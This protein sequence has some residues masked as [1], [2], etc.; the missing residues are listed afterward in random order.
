MSDEINRGGSAFPINGYDYG[1]TLRDYIAI[2]V[3]QGIYAF[4]P[5]GRTFEYGC[6][7]ETY[8]SR[9]KMALNQ[10][11]AYLKVRDGK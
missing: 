5:R 6:D 9:A 4:D 8:E 7:K 2:A 10:A 1:M 3:L 11:D